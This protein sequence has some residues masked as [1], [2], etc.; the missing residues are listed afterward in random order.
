[1]SQI[2]EYFQCLIEPKLAKTAVRV[3]LFVGT[4]LF[5]I[6]HGAALLQGQMSR[7]RWISGLLTYIVPYLVNIHGQFISRLEKN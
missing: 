7:E 2:R 3:A 1:M 5:I 6:N 4:L